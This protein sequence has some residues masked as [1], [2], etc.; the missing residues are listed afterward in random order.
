MLV[1]LTASLTD[2]PLKEDCHTCADSHSEKEHA[3]YSGGGRK[4]KKGN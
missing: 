1:F 3:K 2:S 4:S